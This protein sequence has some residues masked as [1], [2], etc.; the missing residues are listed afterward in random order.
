VSC[1]AA[2]A[3]IEVLEDGLVDNAAKV[4]AYFNEQLIETAKAVTRSS[5]MCAA[6]A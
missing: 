1:R 3:T 4:G 2:L 5:G 6:S